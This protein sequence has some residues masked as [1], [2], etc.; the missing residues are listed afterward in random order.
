M[1]LKRLVVLALASKL[2]SCMPAPTDEPNEPVPTD[3]PSDEPTEDIASSFV[4]DLIANLTQAEEPE[5]TNEKRGLFSCTQNSLTVNLGYAKYRGY[6]N[7][8]TGLNYWKGC[9][10]IPLLKTPAISPSI[11]LENRC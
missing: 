4:S 7:A 11:V 1:T 8:S 10:R 2:V 5:T 9:G 6:Y 3:L